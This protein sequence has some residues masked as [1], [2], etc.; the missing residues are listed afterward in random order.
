MV[1]KEAGWTSHDVVAK[2][3]GV[4]RQRR[5]GHAGTLDPSATGVLLVGVMILPGCSILPKKAAPSE[6]KHDPPQ[7]SQQVAK[8]GSVQGKGFFH[9][10]HGLLAGI[11]PFR[12]KPVPP[13]ALG[14]RR[15]GT[16]RTLSN[17]G[18]YVIVELEPGTLVAPDSK[19][20]IT[21]TGAAPA[22]LR[23]SEIR[24]PYFVADV[25]SG[26]PEPGDRVQQ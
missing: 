9:Q 7:T 4:L 11:H 20:V 2:L 23:V 3:R 22:T 1:D 12:H 25:E 19:L 8:P 18:S 26:N 24:P 15:I 13:K 10:L 21:S 17:D 14:L 16:V 5:T 6:P